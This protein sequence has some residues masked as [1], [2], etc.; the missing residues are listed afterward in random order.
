M[1][2]YCV[3]VC[4]CVYIQELPETAPPGQLPYS[5]D[6]ALEDD[7]VDQVSVCACVRAS[8]PLVSLVPL[9]GRFHVCTASELDVCVVV[10]CMCPQ[11]KPGDRVALVGVYKAVTGKMSGP[12]SGTFRC[13]HLPKH[14]HTRT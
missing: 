6:I 1:C 5:V 7:L 8:Q 11:V 2:A 9:C 10:V 4:V 3:C 14:T 12:S 13:V